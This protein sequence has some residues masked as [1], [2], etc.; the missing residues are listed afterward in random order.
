MVAWPLMTPTLC[1]SCLES[2]FGES[3]VPTSQLKSE[4][5]RSD[6]RCL[7]AFERRLQAARESGTVTPAPD[8]AAMV[9]GTRSQVAVVAVAALTTGQ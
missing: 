2:A 8:A 1:T 4:R 6:F 3:H 5:E 7:T 9:P